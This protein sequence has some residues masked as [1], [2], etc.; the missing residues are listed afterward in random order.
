MSRIGPG[1]FRRLTGLSLFWRFYADFSFFHYYLC[2]SR[3]VLV[4]A[5]IRV[6]DLILRQSMRCVPRGERGFLLWMMGGMRMEVVHGV[7]F[8]LFS[9]SIFIK[10]CL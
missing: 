6:K 4:G 9:M 2:R 8:V 10:T 5:M 7:V 1:I 3:A